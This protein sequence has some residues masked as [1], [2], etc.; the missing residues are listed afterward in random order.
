MTLLDLPPRVTIERQENEIRLRIRNLTT[1]DQGISAVDVLFIV[2][3]IILV[4]RYMGMSW[5]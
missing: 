4:N 3:M 5:C 1:E 2:C